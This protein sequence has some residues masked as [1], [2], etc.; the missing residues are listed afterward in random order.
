DLEDALLR[1]DAPADRRL[2]DADPFAER[3]HRDLA[4]LSAEDRRPPAARADL[5]GRDPEQRALPGAVRADNAPVLSFTDAPVDT[6]EDGA[7]HSVGRA[8]DGDVLEQDDHAP[9]LVGTGDAQHR[10]ADDASLGEVVERV[11]HLRE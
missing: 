3:G 6:G 1:I 10:P 9:T 4:E 2:D 7:P 11:V 5:C 8:P